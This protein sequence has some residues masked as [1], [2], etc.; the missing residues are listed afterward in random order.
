MATIIIAVLL[1][2]AVVLLLILVIK[3]Q[4]RI[5]D[6][7]QQR[8][9]IEAEEHQVFGFLH[10]LGEAFA[11]KENIRATQL[12]K[13]IVEGSVRVL[14]A[15]G[16]MLYLKDRHSERLIPTYV[17]AGCPA[18]VPIPKHILQQAESTPQAI[19]SYVRLHAIE[20]GEGILGEVW[21]LRAPMR[22][23]EG[24]VGADE[25]LAPLAQNRTPVHCALVA[26]LLYAGDWMGVLAVVNGPMS[27]KFSES[28]LVTFLNITE[29]SAFAL[30]NA[31]IYLEAHEKRRI[32]SDLQI[33]RDIQR[34]LLPSSP[35]EVP[36][37]QISGINIPARYVSGDYFD[38]I[39]VADKSWGVAIADV[40]GKGVP[41]SLIMAMCRSVLRSQAP[42]NG[43]A[44]VVLKE[45]N[46]QLFPDIKEDMFISMAYLILNS[47]NGEVTLSRAGHD[48]PLLYRS[49]TKSIQ[50]LTPPGMAVGIDS[51][52]VFDRINSDYQLTLEP[53]DCIVLYTDGV[54]EAVNDMGTEFGMAKLIQSVQDSASEGAP[55]VIK[56]LTTELRGFVG[57]YPQSDDITVIVIRKL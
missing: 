15:H 5:E 23:V 3:Q 53:N 49:A 45:V 51:G 47:E 39:R 30:F 11:E 44:S 28:D 13:H 19:E 57:E 52:A 16:G 36:G 55:A 29:Q 12:H 22:V 50:K 7:R 24:E 34:I 8:E 31:N 2:I 35:P 17:S 20:P 37:F 33:A 10:E 43:S 56:T 14:E 48:P 4:E 40:S 32:D 9:E 25:L 1:A 18:L 21:S 38:Y 46:R 27:H 26:P 6:L 54:T 41:A 42:G